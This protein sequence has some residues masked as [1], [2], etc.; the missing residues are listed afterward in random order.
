L[1]DLAYIWYIK[2]E[3]AIISFESF[4][5]LLLQQFSSNAPSTLENNSTLMSQLSVTMAREIIKT[6]TYFR[7]SKDDVLDWLER[8]EQRFKMAN[9]DDEHKLRYISIHLQED[10]YRWWVQASE[11]INSWSNFVEEIKQAFGSTKMKEIAFEQLRWYKQSVNQSIT[12]YYAKIIELCRRV[13]VT[14]SDSMKLQYLKSG[15][16]NSL[17]LC[18]ALHDPQSVEEFLS[19]ARKVED[20]LAFM[21]LVE[22]VE[23]YGHQ[24][25]TNFNERNDI[26]EVIDFGLEDTNKLRQN[27]SLKLCYTCGTPGH[28]ARDCARSPFQPLA[29]TIGHATSKKDVN[30]S[31]SSVYS[32]SLYVCGTIK[33]KPMRLMIDTGASRTF[34]SSR[35]L[36][37]IYFKQFN[38]QADERV[39]LADGRTSIVV[40]GEVNVPIQFGKTTVII[41]ASVV[42]DLCA[43]YILGMDFIEKYQMIINMQ[44]RTISIFNGHNRIM[45]SIYREV[46][47]NDLQCPYSR[48]VLLGT[49]IEKNDVRQESSLL[50]DPNVK[51]STCSK[52]KQSYRQ[53]IREPPP[54]AVIVPELHENRVSA[55]VKQLTKKQENQQPLKQRW[56]SFR[57]MPDQELFVPND[58]LTS[59]LSS[60]WITVEGMN[61]RRN[62]SRNLRR[63]KGRYKYKIIRNVPNWVKIH[64]VKHV[65]YQLHINYVHLKIENGKVVIGLKT[66]ELVNEYENSL[67][68]DV[69]DKMC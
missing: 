12:Q 10:A 26:S 22:T 13:D 21:N 49:I 58:K 62:R 69:F 66:P 48:K 64:H 24:R 57:S 32:S 7:G 3:Q 28:Y 33:G 60:D 4:G 43:D 44:Y 2:N 16:K 18:I 20:T 41:R 54:K 27:R 67:Q 65:L 38:G 34:V 23:E 46:K 17:K 1:E 37:A 59:N 63:R 51:M 25:V 52:Q 35:T 31:F 55:V 29:A 40:G 36:Q 14:M 39:F 42:K 11:R 47:P 19:Y 9:W 30:E 50:E 5:K 68:H 15:V 6:P 8:L 56:A 45:L 61:A 53:V